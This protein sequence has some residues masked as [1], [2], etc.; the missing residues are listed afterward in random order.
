L[1]CV[2]DWAAITKENF[3]FQHQLQFWPGT[4]LGSEKKLNLII[5]KKLRMTFNLQYI[6]KNCV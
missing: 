2:N 4:W 1:M 6:S 5:R 3:G